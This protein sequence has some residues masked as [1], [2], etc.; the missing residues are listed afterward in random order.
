MTDAQRRARRQQRVEELCAAALRALAG[1][2]DLHFRGRRLHRGE[3][4]LPVFAP[5]LSPSPDDDDFGSLRGA[6]DGIAL[7]LTRSDAALHAR[8]APESA[9]ERWVFDALEQ[10]RVESLAPATLPGVVRNLRHR[11]V[12]W[13]LACERDGL[14]E[15][16]AGLLLYTV[17]QVCRAQILAEPVLEETDGL[18]EA[19]RGALMPR[20]GHALAGLRRTRTDQAAFAARALAIARAVGD[21]VRDAVADA[22]ERTVAEGDAPA[23]R[24]ARRALAAWLDPDPPET[25]DGADGLAAPGSRPPPADAPAYRVFTRAFDRELRA[26]AQVRPAELIELRARLDARIAAQCVNLP[27]LARALEALLATPE[28]DGWESGLE[29]GVI[30]GRRLAR[31]IASP[32]ERRLFR[33]ERAEPHADWVVGVLV[34]C[35]GSMKPHAESVAMIVDLLARAF[36][37]AGV[38]TEVLG[39]TTGAWHGG[40]ALRAWQQAGRP[41][42]PGRLNEVRH[43]VFKDADTPWRR[44]RPAI[45][46]LLR[47]DLFREGVDGEAVDWACARLTDRPQSRKL[48]LVVSDGCPRDTATVLANGELLL[49]A[50]L[51]EVVLRREREG[52]AIRAIGVGLDLSA[53]YGFSQ[54]LD[55]SEPPGNRVFAEILRL[56]EGRR[57]R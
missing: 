4:R 32:A 14:T 28:R 48:L 29:S 52:I 23:E 34:D 40:R 9:I 6:A 10:F 46:A 47:G 27:R 17:A 43:L 49:D 15:T 42:A 8:C 5:H 19:T 41:A 13:A 30:D 31:L 25:A 56:I 11:H 20:I 36:E 1:E 22:G 35:S 44:A 24:R 54:V 18:I 50:H 57:A 21:L 12:R 45:A 3:R 37:M 33:A 26:A 39:F 16:D 7:R 38:A 53:Y 51:R 2:T 55:L